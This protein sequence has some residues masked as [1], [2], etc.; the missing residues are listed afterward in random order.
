MIAAFF[1]VMI[2]NSSSFMYADI[3][4]LYRFAVPVF[5][6]ISGYFYCVPKE[7]KKSRI[8]KIFILTIVTNIAFL[9]YQ[10]VISLKDTG[11]ADYFANTFTVE[12][13]LKFVLLNDSPFGA[14]LWF[15]SALLYCMIIDYFFSEFMMKRKKLCVA[16]IV[17]L[18]LCDLVF[19]K[20]SMV[21]FNREFDV[22]FIRNF[23]FVG[24][25]YFYIGKLFKSVDVNAIKLNNASLIILAVL[26]CVTTYLEKHMLMYFNL[27]TAREQYLSTTLFTLVVFVLALKNPL[28]NP[29]RLLGYVAYSGKKYSLAIY[30]VHPV[31]V[32]ASGFVVKHLGPMF[33][34][35]YSFVS[36]FIL[37]AAA[38]I[39]AII[40]YGIKDKMLGIIKKKN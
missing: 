24:I 7:K 9:L 12:K 10:M 32:F 15:L 5:F 11:I 1:V 25:P 30:I 29:G 36:G 17:V 16:L 37:F 14:H 33:T 27:D 6:V 26:F 8:K 23:I 18:L 28:E 35:V 34:T 2:H 40:Y 3:N 13:M 21:L 39:I 38:W 4:C 22:A 20:Y 31:L 19:G